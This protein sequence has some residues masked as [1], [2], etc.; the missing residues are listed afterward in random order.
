MA[1]FDEDEFVE[2]LKCENKGKEYCEVSP[3]ID[4]YKHCVL[5]LKIPLKDNVSE[6]LKVNDNFMAKVGRKKR[7]RPFEIVSSQVKPI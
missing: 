6:V 3:K 1:R 2:N 5:S 7:K 4:F